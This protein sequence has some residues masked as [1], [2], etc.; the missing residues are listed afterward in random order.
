MENPHKAGSPGALWWVLAAGLL[1]RLVLAF[2]NLPTLIML[3]VPDDTFH[4]LKIAQNIA[5]GYG[6]T[7]DGFHPTNGYH[8]LWMG[9]LIP[10]FR[11][12]PDRL[13]MPVNLALAL[14]A[15]LD[16]GTAACIYLLARTVLSSILLRASGWREALC[17]RRLAGH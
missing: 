4:Y 17:V 8:P 13:E 15:F 9:L 11:A 10:L 7:F 6:S 16:V 2:T 5:A 1:I 14:Q 3:N 12:L